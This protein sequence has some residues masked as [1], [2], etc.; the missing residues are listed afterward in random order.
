[1]DSQ[2]AR[3]LFGTVVIIDTKTGE[4][5]MLGK[6]RQR[7]LLPP[8]ST[9][10]ETAEEIVDLLQEYGHTLNMKKAKNGDDSLWY[11]CF[12]KEDGR[13]Y[14]ASTAATAAEA[15]CVAALAALKGDNVYKGVKAA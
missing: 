7:M 10:L 5:Y 4:S 11:A 2:V 13:R 8:F 15:I 6:D 12:S 1:M 9:D 3:S 14:V